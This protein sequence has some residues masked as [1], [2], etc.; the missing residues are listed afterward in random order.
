VVSFYVVIT[1]AG[2]QVEIGHGARTVTD[3]WADK[4]RY[5]RISA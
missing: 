2:S 3:H 4:R 5:D 1:P